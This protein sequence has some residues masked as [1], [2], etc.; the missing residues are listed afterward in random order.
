[1][2]FREFNISRLVREGI[3]FFIIVSLFSC[4]PTTTLNQ[5]TA[6]PIASPPRVQVTLLPPMTIEPTPVCIQILGVNLDVVP[7]SSNSIRVKITGL[8]PSEHVTFV[9]YSELA[10][11]TFKIESSPLEGA[12]NNGSIEYIEGGLDKASEAHFKEWKIQVIHSRGV[13]CATINLP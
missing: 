2:I 11:Q 9:F 1:M 5:G 7:L 13:A 6:I 10:E 12:D 8:K 4:Q 3:Y